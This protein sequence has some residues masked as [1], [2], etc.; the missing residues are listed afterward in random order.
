MK[1]RVETL[2]NLFV[3]CLLLGLLV[4][5]ARSE[6]D[7]HT[8][9]VWLFEEGKGNK[10]EDVSG[11]GH[12]GKLT[13]KP[14]WVGSKF[15]KGLSLP[16]DASG[17]V[18]VESSQKLKVKQL[19]IEALIMPTKPTGKWQGIICKQ[20]AGCGNR[21]YGIWV[22]A[23]NN[24]LHAQI[25]SGGACDFSID[26]DSIIT[27]KKWHYV[28]FTYDGKI[29]RTY[30]DGKLESE[31][32]YGKE[33]FFSDDPITI[34]VPNLNNANGFL[35]VIDEAR[36]SNVAR[37]EKEINQ[38]LKIGFAKLLDVQPKGKLTPVWGNLKANS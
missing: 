34:G 9:A 1:N 17:Y 16:G 32:A 5:N 37:T 11:N 4:T 14:K 2:I 12:D 25:G 26:G 10:V 6:I 19:T 22:H 36:I 33:P 30:V 21:N 7:K 13:G 3:A 31:K 35:G 29:G 27:D 28:A 20:K 23:D 15:G 24:K 38:A 18:V 8:I